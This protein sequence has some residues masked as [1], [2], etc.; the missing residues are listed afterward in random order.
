MLQHCELYFSLFGWINSYRIPF[1]QKVLL[2][3]AVCVRIMVTLH[4]FKMTPF[5]RTWNCG[6]RNTKWPRRKKT[7][8][9]VSPVLEEFAP[10]YLRPEA[11]FPATKEQTRMLISAITLIP[12][13][14]MARRLFAASALLLGTPP[15]S[16]MTPSTRI[17]NFG[18]RQSNDTIGIHMLRIWLYLKALLL[19]L[20]ETFV[21]KVGDDILMSYFYIVF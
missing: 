10:Y 8:T 1:Y 4:T 21:E 13:C 7:P 19:L 18:E 15:T 17:W 9:H 11:V 3:F 6:A 12:C 16:K 2:L 14:L 5:I 20:C